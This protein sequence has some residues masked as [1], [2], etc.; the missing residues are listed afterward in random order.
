MP[1]YLDFFAIK[2]VPSHKRDRKIVTQIRLSSAARSPMLIVSWNAGSYQ[3]ALYSLMGSLHM[4]YIQSRSHVQPACDTV[5]QSL[6]L[7][8][9]LTLLSN[10]YKAK[11]SGQTTLP[12][13]GYPNVSEIKTLIIANITPL[14]KAPPPRKY[15]AVVRRRRTRRAC[16]SKSI[17]RQSTCAT[18]LRI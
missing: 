16:V 18:I 4:S 5:F 14:G 1:R 8:S 13:M 6:T 9:R 3:F 17:R 7:D 12:S 15:S 2:S 10:S 11:P